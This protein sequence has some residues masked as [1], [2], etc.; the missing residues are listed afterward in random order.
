MEIVD[1]DFK[2]GFVAAFQYSVKVVLYYLHMSFLETCKSY[3]LCSAGLNIRKNCSLS[4]KVTI[5][6]SFGRRLC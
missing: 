4:L 1:K 5:W 3:R 6:L 2:N